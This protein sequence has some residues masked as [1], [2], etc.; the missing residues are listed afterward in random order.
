[1][2][3]KRMLIPCQRGV[4]GEIWGKEIQERRGADG[5]GWRFSTNEI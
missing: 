1:M 2:I 5:K 3:Y 4:K